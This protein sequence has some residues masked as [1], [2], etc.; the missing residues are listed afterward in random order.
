MIRA[1]RIYLASKRLQRIV[2]RRRTSFEV[3]DFRKRRAAALKRR[4]L[5]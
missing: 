4:A 3:Q 1:F 2:E 5:E